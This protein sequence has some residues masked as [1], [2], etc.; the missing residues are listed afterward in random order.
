MGIKSII[1]K[2]IGYS[3]SKTLKFYE[4]GD[5]CCKRKLESQG[6]DLDFSPNDYY[7]ADVL[8]VSEFITVKSAK[9]LRSIY[10]QMKSPKWVVQLGDCA[11]CNNFMSNSY[12]RIKLEDIMDVDIKIKSCPVSKKEFQ[13][14]I[15]K[16]EKKVKQY[17]FI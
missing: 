1:N 15:Q 7:D 17:N 12:N 5:G 13:K 11:N 6:L 10:S 9:A 8:V 3:Y 16:L 2:I 4:F 14:S